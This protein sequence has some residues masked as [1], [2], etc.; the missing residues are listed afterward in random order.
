[1][2][3]RSL[4][5][6]VLADHSRDSFVDLCTV[7]LI[8]EAPIAAEARI[9]VRVLFFL[10]VLDGLERLKS[11]EQVRHHGPWN[12]IEFDQPDRCACDSHGASPVL[13]ARNTRSD[14]FLVLALVLCS[15]V[16]S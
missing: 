4:E 8:E 5:A 6:L 11:F 13:A 1:M 15:L 9:A 14:L 12:L 2:S 3:E 7:T 10:G 16:I